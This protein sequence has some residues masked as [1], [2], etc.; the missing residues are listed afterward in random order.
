MP[1]FRDNKARVREA[2]EQS[3]WRKAVHDLGLAPL[4][5]ANACLACLPQGTPITD[6]AAAVIGAEVGALA[7]DMRFQ[8]QARL[9]VR[10]LMWHMNEESGNVGWGV[11]EA[12]GEILMASPSFAAQYHRVFFSYVLRTGSDDNFCD[13]PLVR[14]ACYA[15]ILRLV[16]ARPELACSARPALQQGAESDPDPLCRAEAQNALDAL[17]VPD[18]V[19]AD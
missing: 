1:H 15:A 12:F 2:L 16:L 14:R 9:F 13:Q 7:E 8:E 19:R 6:R 3:D 11:P 5:L 4:P 18:P 17:P 10:R